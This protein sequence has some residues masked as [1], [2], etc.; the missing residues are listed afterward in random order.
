MK[1]II[2]ATLGALAALFPPGRLEIYAQTPGERMAAEYFRLQ[3]E[4]VAA[5]TLADVHTLADWQARR[6]TYRQQLL[7]MLGLSPPPP[8]G[9][10][11]A[12]L[13]GKVETEKFTV[14]KIHFQSLPG[15]YVTANLYL[16]KTLKGPAPAVLYLCGHL[17]TIKNGIAYGTKVGYQHHPAWLAEHGYV[18]LIIDT[19]EMGEI[20]GEHH[21]THR[22]GMWWWPTRGYTPAGVET[23]NAM[24]A[25]DYLETRPE[26]DPQRIGVT[27]RSGGGAYT[28]FLAAVDDRPSALIPV[29]GVTD[30]TNHVVDG[31][32]EGHCDCMFQLNTYG[33]DFS[34]LA[35]LAAPRPLLLSNSDKDNIFPLD[36]VQ[37]IHRDLKRIYKLYNAEDKLGLLITEG[38]HSDTQDLQVPAFRWLNRW[39]KKDMGLLSEPALKRFEVE[40]LKVFTS[41]PA[42]QINTRIH[43]TFVP[44]APPAALPATRQEWR[45]LAARWSAVLREKVFNNWPAA[46][47]RP[48]AKVVSDVTRNGVRARLV[49]FQPDDAYRLQLALLTHARQRPA[50][51]AV[52]VL[53]EEEWRQWAAEGGRYFPALFASEKN[54]GAAGAEWRKLLQQGTAIALVLPRGVG[55]TAWRK[56]KETHIRR[57]F[58]LLGQSLETM[59]VW[60]TRAALFAL[61]ALPA[62]GRLPVSLRGARTM[63]V[64]ALFAALFE[65]GVKR[66]ELERPPATLARGP[67]FPNVLRFF[68]LPQLVA[69]ALPRSV[70]LTGVDPGDWDWSLKAARLLEGNIT[71][72][73]DDR[74]SEPRGISVRRAKAPARA[75]AAPHC[76][77]SPGRRSGLQENYC[78]QD[79]ATYYCLL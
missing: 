32:I 7:E 74:Q 10:L 21:G 58:L 71:F 20:E 30:M 48:A 3:T 66:L 64:V 57:R 54:N 69:L 33:W 35:A 62:L 45:P 38:P 28:W 6:A 60:D 65:D 31:C 42:D 44:A 53:D 77:G 26:V 40:Q 37:R 13:T 11:K 16:P 12:T 4:R 50:R 75:G 36:G 1:K 39:L 76:V 9:D 63:S 55:P 67:S 34:L 79:R 43:D 5:R 14:E 8:R 51:L 25:L 17:R 2:L 52:R 47:P 22:R 59:Q 56:E 18:A 15:L 29:A 49:E 78:P 70:N 68:D 23:W 46:D 41:L 19:L 61:R 72:S 73:K 24:R 27:G